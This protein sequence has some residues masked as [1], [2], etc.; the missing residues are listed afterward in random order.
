MK[1]TAGQDN[2]KTALN[3]VL[4]VPQIAVTV[5][6]HSST[7]PQSGYTAFANATIDANA[8]T[9][10]IPI[11]A[12]ESRYFILNGNVSTRISSTAIV[13]GNLVLTYE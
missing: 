2:F 1:G 9:V 12:A 7:N 3:Y 11:A 13:N 8:K 10:T 4:F 5:T 6:V